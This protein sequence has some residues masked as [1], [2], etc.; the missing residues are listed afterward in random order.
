MTAHCVMH[1]TPA[2]AERGPEA[3]HK[4]NKSHLW[5]LNEWT[6]PFFSS[7]PPPSPVH[8]KEQL[9]KGSA[10]RDSFT[11]QPGCK[12]DLFLKLSCIFT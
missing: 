11:R 10:N 1:D 9:S 2:A 5:G 8:H 3:L 12:T 6:V 7:L 4:V